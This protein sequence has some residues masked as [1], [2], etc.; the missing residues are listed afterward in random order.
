MTF[1]ECIDNCLYSMADELAPSYRRF[2]SD[3]AGL[4]VQ[5]EVDSVSWTL[6]ITH[7]GHRMLPL[8]PAASARVVT[9]NN[10]IVQL[11]RG[12]VSLLEALKTD[13]LLLFGKASDLGRFNEALLRYVHLM[14]KCTKA[15]RIF[16]RYENSLE[17]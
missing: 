2:C 14:M 6:S 1:A 12:D 7:A 4:C 10:T 8:I 9:S 3:M 15:Q 13:Q 16:E 11:A 17:T 5:F